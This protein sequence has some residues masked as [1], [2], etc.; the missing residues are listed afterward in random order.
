MGELNDD[1]TM[2]EQGK[3]QRYQL[4]EDDSEEQ[5][6]KYATAETEDQEGTIRHIYWTCSLA[7]NQDFY[8]DITANKINTELVLQ[9]IAEQ[10]CEVRKFQVYG[11]VPFKIARTTRVITP[12][13]VRWLNINKGDDESPEI[14]CRMVAK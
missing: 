9:A 3:R 4:T 8:D 12:I 14:R 13:G 7:N 10:L 2:T 11:K 1:V 5:A 6:K